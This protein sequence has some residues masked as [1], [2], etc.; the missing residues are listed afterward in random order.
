MLAAAIIVR[1]FV[2]IREE[3]SPESS[4]LHRAVSV[5]LNVQ[6][7]GVRSDRGWKC[8]A[9][10]CPNLLLIVLWTAVDIDEVIVACFLG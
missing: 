5:E 2:E 1:T 10:K 3:D 7:I 4:P 9:A 6:F 8:I